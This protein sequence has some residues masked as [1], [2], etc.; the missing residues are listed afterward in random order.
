[1]FSWL[2]I[3]VS[4]AVIPLRNVIKN[5]LKEQFSALKGNNSESYAMVSGKKC[6]VS[7]RANKITGFFDISLKL[8]GKTIPLQ[9]FSFSLTCYHTTD[10]SQSYA[11]KVNFK[12]EVAGH[13]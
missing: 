2:V 7:K 12:V 11:G 4:N 10:H 6:T 1:M 13:S 9:F 3:F 5:P 8:W